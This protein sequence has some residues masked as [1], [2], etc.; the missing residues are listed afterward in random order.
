MAMKISTD[1]PGAGAGGN[2]AAFLEAR[3]GAGHVSDP[4]RYAGDD[5]S[6]APG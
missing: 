5:S 6:P 4:T 2:V 1:P 3:C